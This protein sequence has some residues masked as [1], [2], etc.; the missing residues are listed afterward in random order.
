MTAAF[1]GVGATD[2]LVSAAF[3][4]D[5]SFLGRALARLIVGPHCTTTIK[6]VMITE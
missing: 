1:R 5:A 6:S 2:P 3:A 4:L